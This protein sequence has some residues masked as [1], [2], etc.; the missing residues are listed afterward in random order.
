MNVVSR[1]IYNLNDQSPFWQVYAV[2]ILLV[3]LFS[4]SLSILLMETEVS[5][6]LASW[7]SFIGG[8]FTVVA[9]FASVFTYLK[10]KREYY[11]NKENDLYHDL[12]FNQLPSWESE[13]LNEV[14][15]VIK[16]LLTVAGLADNLT[17]S[18]E[19][20][21]RATSIKR[22]EDDI[23]ITS[24][25]IGVYSTIPDKDKLIDE[26]KVLVAI[27]MDFRLFLQ[28]YK[29]KINSEDNRLSLAINQLLIRNN[30]I[31]PLMKSKLVRV[32]SKRAVCTPQCSRYMHNTFI[33]LTESCRTCIQN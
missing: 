15:S 4:G 3:F 32:R 12:V 8:L 26:T 2:F 31:E 23:L 11:Q 33:S 1:W 7:G 18:E 21:S 17:N 5:N 22:L 9:V 13:I 6:R 29:K 25:Q 24:S 30:I 10:F 27:C 20:E 16:D 28:E 19:L 14:F